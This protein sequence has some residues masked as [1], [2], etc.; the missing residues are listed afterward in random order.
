MNHAR[1]DRS[2]RLQRVHALLAD[3]REYS[4]LEI[5]RQARVCAVNSVI[6]ELR[7]NGCIIT[8]RWT[9]SPRNERIFVYRM[10]TSPVV[11]AR[12]KPAHLAAPAP[13]AAGGIRS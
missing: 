11:P 1:L 10:T 9:V 4:T 6:S 3:C 13:P 2:K 8:G 5:A 12:R 7:A